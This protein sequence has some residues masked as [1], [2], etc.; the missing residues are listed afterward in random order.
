M[1]D[2]RK[3]LDVGDMVNEIE[4]DV[5]EITEVLEEVDWGYIIDGKDE[6]NDALRLLD[7]LSYRLTTR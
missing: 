1:K 7:E 2:Y 5:R 6:V 3:R 4:S